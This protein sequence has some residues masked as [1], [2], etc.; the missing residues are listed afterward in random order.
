[1]TIL[2]GGDGAGEETLILGLLKAFCGEVKRLD[3]GEALRSPSFDGR[4]LSKLAEGAIPPISVTGWRFAGLS[5][6][7]VRK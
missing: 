6:D 2:L 7:G 5:A 1:M 3:C 4:T